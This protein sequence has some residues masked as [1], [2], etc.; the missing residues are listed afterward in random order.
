MAVAKL[1]REQ[2]KINPATR[3]RDK[4]YFPRW[5]VNKRVEYIEDG[6]DFRSY[7]KDLSL[8]GTS[9]FIFGDP[10]A[11]QSVRLKIHLT[12]EDNFEAR[13]RVAWS[14]LGPAQKLFG[15]VFE[16]LSKKAQEL[17]MRY[18]F[19]PQEEELFLYRLIKSVNSKK[20]FLPENPSSPLGAVSFERACSKEVAK[21]REISWTYRGN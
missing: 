4:R 15:V 10:P 13:C 1:E 8:D 7:T 12:E 17:I 14:K 3:R 19:E 9:I 20:E 11:R 6:G 5:E 21:Q 18:A 2:K 16:N